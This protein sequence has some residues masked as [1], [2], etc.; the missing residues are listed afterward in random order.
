MGTPDVVHMKTGEKLGIYFQ[1]T[2]RNVQ[3]V[4]IRMPG[5]E[6]GGIG[7]GF[8]RDHKREAPEWGKHVFM[9]LV[10]GEAADKNRKVVGVLCQ[11]TVFFPKNIPKIRSRKFSMASWKSNR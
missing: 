3:Q 1:N 2:G 11:K 8:I 10:I 7:H 9:S 4:H 5:I 6:S